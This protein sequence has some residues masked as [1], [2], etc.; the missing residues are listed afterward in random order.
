MPRSELPPPG[1][2]EAWLEDLIGADIL[3]G[4]RQAHWGSGSY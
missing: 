3:F 1:E 4:G 2:D